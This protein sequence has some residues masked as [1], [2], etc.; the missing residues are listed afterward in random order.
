MKFIYTSKNQAGT[1]QNGTI[2]AADEAAAIKSLQGEGLFILEIKKAGT[3]LPGIKEDL[4]IPFLGGKVGL[5]DKIIFSKQLAMMIRSGLPLND[6]FNAL[7]E[8]TE[9]KFFS[10]VIGQIGLEVKGGKAL[11]ESMAKY[12]KIFPELHIA[13]V[14]AGEKSGR[15][16]DVL[17]RLSDQLQK[18]YDLISKIKAAATYPILVIGALVAIV[19]LML[20]FVIPQL[21]TV[22]NDMGVELP[23]VTR[24][25][26]GT[27]DIMR[28]YWY[29]F[30]IVLIGGILGIRFWAKTNTGGLIW[31]RFKLKIPLIGGLIK[32]IYMARF[33]RTMGT[34]VASGLPML[35]I[36]ATV[37][38]V[39]TNRVYQL[40]FKKIAKDVEN[41]VQVS[42][43][44]RKQGIF[45]A[46][47]Y[48]LMAV[49][50]K[51]GKLDYVLLSMADF[52]EKEIETTT[53]N[54]ATLI[55]PILIIIIGAGV[56]LVVAAVIMPIYSLVNVI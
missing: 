53:N 54:L 48:H 5:K 22:F 1:I 55:E 34:L 52:F 14:R 45:P 33:A 43:S 50:E 12:P 4:K 19:I 24:I 35:D 13:M 10:K 6:A 20:L 3:K 16:D 37:S 42:T 23:I 25:V 38:G 9:N 56:G 15:L 49:G 2:E 31:D 27:S 36:L 30:L 46:M 29:I 17:D 8:Q 28:K 11:S 26:L 32:K 47:I 44:V 41:G 7:E 40:A 51:S 21:K 18:D 39:I